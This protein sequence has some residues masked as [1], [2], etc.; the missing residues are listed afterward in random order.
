MPE[1]VDAAYGHVTVHHD[2]S[3]APVAVLVD[4]G[5]VVSIEEHWR[6]PW[7]PEEARMV[8]AALLGWAMRKRADDA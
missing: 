2:G 5:D 3:T 4:A 7:S 6:G 8:A 1:Y